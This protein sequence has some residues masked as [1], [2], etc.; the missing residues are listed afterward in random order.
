[1]LRYVH[2]WKHGNNQ[3]NNSQLFKKKGKKTGKIKTTHQNEHS[4]EAYEDDLD[5]LLSSIS[6]DDVKECFGAMNFDDAIKFACDC[7]CKVH[8]PP[9]S[10]STP[11]GNSANSL[12]DKI[13]IQGLLIPSQKSGEKHSHSQPEMIHKAILKNC[14]ST[15]VSA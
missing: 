1:M 9:S 13:G 7:I 5:T 3:N 14:L 6:N 12:Y 10:S 8:K 2:K 15:I 4:D 11:Y